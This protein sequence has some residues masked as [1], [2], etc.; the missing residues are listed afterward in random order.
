M[1]QGGKAVIR[2]WEDVPLPESERADLSAH[3]IDRRISVILRSV[4]PIPRHGVF[5]F[6]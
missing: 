1:L 4:A 2:S 3:R 5:F 6:L